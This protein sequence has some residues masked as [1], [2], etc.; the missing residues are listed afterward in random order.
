MDKIISKLLDKDF[1]TID[2]AISANPFKSGSPYFRV[3]CQVSGCQEFSASNERFYDQY[4]IKKI[5]WNE[6]GEYR[7]RWVPSNADRRQLTW[8]HRSQMQVF[9]PW[10]VDS[11]LHPGWKA[12]STEPRGMLRTLLQILH[13]SNISPGASWIRA[14]EAS[15][16]MTVYLGGSNPSSSLQSMPSEVRLK[17]SNRSSFLNSPKSLKRNN[18]A[19]AGIWFVGN[20][21]QI[22][23]KLTSI[24][25]PKR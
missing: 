19:L 8:W 12:R 24:A 9:G 4:E 13:S 18:N 20:R 1:E 2:E 23:R 16:G 25:I 3:P 21:Q 22:D 10:I 7:Y 15:L 6:W 11:N 17:T 14:I 5:L